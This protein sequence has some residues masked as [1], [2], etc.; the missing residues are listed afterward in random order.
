MGD[1]IK[2]LDCFSVKNVIINIGEN[3]RL[4]NKLIKKL[5][6]KRINYYK[7]VDSLNINNYILYS[8]F[9][10]SQ[11]LRTFAISLA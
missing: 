9:P 5:D 1:S 8:K 4:E 10:I 6:N 11:F 7:N 2:L 3:N